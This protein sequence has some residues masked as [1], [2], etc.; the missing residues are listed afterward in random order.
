MK[1]VTSAVF[2]HNE[3]QA[4]FQYAEYS[5]AKHTHFQ[6]KQKYRTGMISLG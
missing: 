2:Y 3:Y 4:V 6:D 1:N 5:Y